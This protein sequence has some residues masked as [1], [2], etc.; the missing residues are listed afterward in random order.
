M[1][2]TNGC[3][4]TE[5]YNLP[6]ADL[7]WPAQLGKILGQQVKN[8]ALG[9]GSNDRISRT[10]REELIHQTPDAVIVGWTTNNRNELYHVDGFYV[11]ATSHGCLAECEVVP[12]DIDV[13]HKH[14]LT[15]N[16]NQWINYRNWVYNILFFQNYFEKTKIPYLFFTA[17]GENYINEF[18]TQ[19]DKSLWLADQSYQWRDRLKY[20]PERTIHKEWQE[21]VSL[22]QRINLDRWV[23]NNSTTMN[24]YLAGYA[25]DSSG[26]PAAEGH[27]AW[28]KVIANYLR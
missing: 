28:A 26:H 11:R 1:I 20:L 8:L 17:L 25:K 22:C 6:S 13:L 24:E 21:L 7:A 19:T 5:G 9:G 14:W 16:F 10:L 27:L 3:S 2:L 12:A 18:V 4:F 23:F 15:H